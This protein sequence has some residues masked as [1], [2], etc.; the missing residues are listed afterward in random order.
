MISLPAGSR[1]SKYQ[2][3]SDEPLTKTAR[4]RAANRLPFRGTTM[5]CE[6]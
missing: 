4:S 6:S 5:S 3:G 1:I 2:Y